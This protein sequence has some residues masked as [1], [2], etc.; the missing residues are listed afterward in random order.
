LRKQQS[1]GKQKKGK[2]ESHQYFFSFLCTIWNK[3]G[4]LVL[5]TKLKFITNK[6]H[7]KVTWN[8]QKNNNINVR[9]ISIQKN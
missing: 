3:K 8:V 9:I 5:V 1:C 2:I 7:S 6:K 4:P